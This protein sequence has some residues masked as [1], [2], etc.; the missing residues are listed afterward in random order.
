MSLAI[1]WMVMI[2]LVSTSSGERETIRIVDHSEEWISPVV[3]EE[4]NDFNRHMPKVGPK[5]VYIRGGIIVCN[6][7]IALCSGNLEKGFYGWS[8]WY[9]SSEGTIHISNNKALNGTRDSLKNTICHELMHIVANVRRDN[10][11]HPDTSCLFGTLP[12]LGPID[13]KMLRNEYK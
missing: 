10:Q 4:V 13:I 5:L 1:A 3:R 12:H 7:D 11:K 2:P 6:E 9:T 8:V